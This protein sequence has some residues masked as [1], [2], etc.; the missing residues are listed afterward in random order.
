MGEPEYD[1]PKKTIR[2]VDV[3]GKTILLRADFSVPLND[4]AEI[5]SDYRITQTLPT[6]KY[7]LERGCKVV[8]I[9]HLGR[10][11]G[12]RV[13]KFSLE[14]VFEYLQQKLAGIDVSFVEDCIG[15]KVLQKVKAMKGGDIVLLENL[16][17][18]PEEEVNDAQFAERIADATRPNY[19]VQ[20]G[21][22]V[23]HRAHAST[24]AITHLVP[25]LSG[26]LLESEVTALQTAMLDPNQPLIA[27]IGGAKIADKIAFIERLLP[28]A[29]HIL[30]GGVMANTFF[31]YH[32]HNIG[33][34]IFETGQEEVVK[35]IYNKA[36]ENQI[37][38]PSDVAVA[39]A[40]EPKAVRR[41]CPLG[42]VAPDDYILDLGYETMRTFNNH[43][44]KANTVIWNGTL[45][46][47][48]L[49]QFSQG[50]ALL[51]ESIAQQQAAGQ[52][53][54][55]GGGDTADFVLSWLEN[56]KDQKFSH[57]STGGGASLELMS[58]QRLPGVEAL[59]DK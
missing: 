12:E 6:I 7:L 43:I 25:S 8:I 46:Y 35:Q 57:I 5:T 56:H 33:S 30:I 19:F 41:D 49:P 39:T 16:R 40:I 13:K 48:E 38:L 50:S 11:E 9:S 51:A 59:M 20:D 45:G 47:A 2:E 17:F 28:I 44:Q 24:E 10:P 27:V 21:F 14:P 32:G 18:Y 58:G 31:K 36:K 53:S 26:L 23:V 55:I 29:D 1:F 22:G 52:M 3:K 4:K 37:I 15:D 42:D 54:I 34:S